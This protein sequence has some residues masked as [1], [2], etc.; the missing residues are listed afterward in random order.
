MRLAQL[1]FV[2]T[3]THSIPSPL[4]VIDSDRNGV[5]DRAY[6]GDSGGNVWRIDFTEHGQPAP[7]FPAIVDR[8][9]YL[10]RLATLG[11]SGAGDRRFFH[12]P[13]VVQSR[14]S[15]GDYAGVLLVSGNRAAPRE[16]GVRNFAYLLKDRRVAAGGDGALPAPVSAIAHD[17]LADITGGCR[18]A[19]EY[20]CSDTD[21]EPGWKL[22]LV[23][24]GEKGLSTP[25]VTNGK[26]LFTSYVPSTG[27][28]PADSPDTCTAAEGSSRLYAVALRDGSPALTPT[29]QLTSGNEPEDADAPPLRFQATGPGLPADVVPDG[30]RVLLPGGGLAGSELLSVPGRHWW[31]S[32]WREEEVDSL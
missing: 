22:E 3:L 27:E 14:D 8:N 29:G 10:T 5:D 11:G 23:S 9:W 17:V 2:A 31:R 32:Y 4:T 16:V 24:P 30:N 25:L 12:A 6:V 15:A 18:S 7:G 19:A 28:D 13:D 26:L 21:L 1:H 20:T